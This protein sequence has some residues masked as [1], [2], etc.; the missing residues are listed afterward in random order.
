ME[1][2]GQNRI[3][4]IIKY[5]KSSSYINAYKIIIIPAMQ[6]ITSRLIRLFK[7]MKTR[8]LEKPSHLLKPFLKTYVHINKNKTKP[9]IRIDVQNLLRS[10]LV[11]HPTSKT[12]EKLRDDS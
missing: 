9:N 1:R 7:N 4:N 12:P 10:S 5:S 3:W 6:H 11:S 8:L 2:K